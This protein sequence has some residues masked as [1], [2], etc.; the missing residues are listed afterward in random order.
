VSS[1]DVAVVDVG[2]CSAHTVV[3]TV[4]VTV[5]AKAARGAAITDDRMRASE[6]VTARAWAAR[7]KSVSAK[8][9]GRIVVGV[10]WDLDRREQRVK[11]AG[12]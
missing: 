9:R 6:V 4:R 8:E 11:D 3:L 1:L 12:R 5:P 7:A 2:C 10:V